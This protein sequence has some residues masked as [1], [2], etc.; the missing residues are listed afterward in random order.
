[1]SL[2]HAVKMPRQRVS[3]LEPVIGPPRYAQ[4]TGAPTSSGSRWPGARL[5]VGAGGG[6]EAA[7]E[8]AAVLYFTSRA[9]SRWKA[10]PRVGCSSR[11]P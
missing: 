1:V 11:S 3:L 10:V 7:R 9:L 4:L 5:G 2:V 8:T 6:A